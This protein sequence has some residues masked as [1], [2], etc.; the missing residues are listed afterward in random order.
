[1]RE[2]HG[3]PLTIE[4]ADMPKCDTCTKKVLAGFSVTPEIKA[5]MDAKKGQ[6]YNLSAIA[7]NLFTAAIRR[8]QMTGSYMPPEIVD[9]KDIK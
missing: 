4:E 8:E 7:C 3:P 9:V 1:M 2:P 6:G 5:W